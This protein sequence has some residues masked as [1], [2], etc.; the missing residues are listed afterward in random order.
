MASVA[1]VLNPGPPVLYSPNG[2]GVI[3]ALIT[4]AIWSAQGPARG[5]CRFVQADGGGNNHS[6]RT[7][8]GNGDAHAV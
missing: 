5:W 3:P 8:H 1:S 7:W 6:R 2:A 4:H